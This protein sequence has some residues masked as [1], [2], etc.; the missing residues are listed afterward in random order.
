[1]NLWLIFLLTLASRL[2]FIHFNAAEHTDAIWQMTLFQN[3]TDLYLPLYPA[4]IWCVNLVCHNLE[5]AGKLVSML[6]GALLVLPLYKITE[7]VFSKSAA[8]AVLGLYLLS[9]EFIRWD[10]RISGDSLFV[11]F[12]L[13]G[14][15]TWLHFYHNRDKGSLGSLIFVAG[16]ASLTRFEGMSFLGLILLALVLYIKERKK[17]KAS[18]PFALSFLPWLLLYFW[19]HLRGFAFG[20]WYELG[21][22]WGNLYALQQLARYMGGILVVLTL[23]VFFL[24]CYGLGQSLKEGNKTQRVLVWSFF[25]FLLLWAVSRAYMIVFTTRYFL[26]ILA[27]LLIFAGAGLAS[28]KLRAK[29]TLL[30]LCLVFNLVFTV[31]F[32]WSEKD[33]FG[34]IKR[35]AVFIKDNLPKA[36]VA[37]DEQVKVPFWMGR[38][39]ASLDGPVLTKGTT[40]VVLH[41]YYSDLTKAVSLLQQ[42]YRLKVVDREI[43]Q[44]CLLLP[45][46]Y[47]YSEPAPI[48]SLTTRNLYKGFESVVLEVRAK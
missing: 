11:F 36:V 30:C 43:S 22:G 28:F 8:L 5:L 37:S 9:P 7:R 19:V 25:Y 13:W 4:V 42:H 23:P 44:V 17:E 32:M 1:M 15:G 29:T 24:A 14:L 3:S 10:V 41:S 12:F 27:V 34:D 47:V 40:H 31:V 26:P 33:F 46:F 38:P 18:L 2:V 20:G 48:P 35:S 16:L 45:D 6:A 39:V 21:W